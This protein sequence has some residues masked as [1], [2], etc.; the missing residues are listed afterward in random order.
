MTSGTM[1]KKVPC[2]T[3]K[4]VFYR[5]Q[6]YLKL[7]YKMDLNKL[8]Q[9]L[10]ITSEKVK[11]KAAEFDRLAQVRAPG[12]LGQVSNSFNCLVT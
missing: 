6:K 10:K 1:R 2:N 3:H 7:S 5:Q 11:R 8:C 9:E 4:N 12:G